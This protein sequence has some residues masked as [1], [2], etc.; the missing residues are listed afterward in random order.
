M[1]GIGAACAPLRLASQLA[2]LKV[3]PSV[4]LTIATLTPAAAT[5]AQSTACWASDTSTS[6]KAIY[7]PRLVGLSPIIAD[8]DKRGEATA[9]SG[10]GAPPAGCRSPAPSL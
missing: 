2:A 1:I 8:E 7:R 5:F 9:A 6:S 10:L 3:A 4:A